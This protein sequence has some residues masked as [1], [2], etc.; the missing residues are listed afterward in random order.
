M[1]KRKRRYWLKVVLG[2]GWELVNQ[3]Q[4]NAKPLR[5]ETEEEDYQ[6]QIICV[7]Y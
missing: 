1:D 7:N 3:N 4:N 6:N 5:R 2:L